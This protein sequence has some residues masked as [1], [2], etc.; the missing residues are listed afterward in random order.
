MNLRLL[1]MRVARLGAAIATKRVPE[2]RQANERSG[3]M[4]AAPDALTSPSDPRAAGF[5]VA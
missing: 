3:T 2:R 1:Q 5:F 4:Y